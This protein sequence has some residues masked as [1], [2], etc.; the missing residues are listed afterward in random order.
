MS[1][2]GGSKNDEIKA[3]RLTIG[4][5]DAE[6]SSLREQNKKLREIL[7][8]VNGRIDGYDNLCPVCHK[9]DRHHP[10]YAT[11]TEDC[12]L[13]AAIQEQEQKP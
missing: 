3:L 2:R 6:L 13:A 5:R 11:H 4:Q 12:A 7:V 9:Y 1:A 10:V 8:E